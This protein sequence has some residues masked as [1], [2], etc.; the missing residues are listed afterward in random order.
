VW[1]RRGSL[2]AIGLL[3]LVGFA[4]ALIAIPVAAAS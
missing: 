1:W 2:L 3:P 4:F